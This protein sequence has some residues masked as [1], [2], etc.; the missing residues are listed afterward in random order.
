MHAGRARLLADMHRAVSG[1]EDR[2][3]I[4]AETATQFRDSDNAVAG[5]E[6]VVNEK[7]VG[8]KAGAFDRRQCFGDISIPP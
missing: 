8:Q 7:S 1:D 4:P 3:Q 6:V 5:V 2:R